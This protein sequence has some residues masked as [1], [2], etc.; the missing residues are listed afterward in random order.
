MEKIYKNGKH[1]DNIKARYIRGNRI[2]ISANAHIGIKT[3]R[4]D[5][6]E[7]LGYNLIF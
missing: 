1:L 3:S 2:Y 4:R 5:D 7:S 6:I